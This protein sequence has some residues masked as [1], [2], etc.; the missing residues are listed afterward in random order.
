MTNFHDFS[1]EILSIQ[2]PC[3]TIVVFLSDHFFISSTSR[4]PHPKAHHAILFRHGTLLPFPPRRIPN[5]Q[6]PLLNFQSHPPRQPFLYT[7]T[8]HPPPQP[9]YSASRPSHLHHPPPH[10]PPP[11]QHPRYHNPS[12]QPTTRP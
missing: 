3:F 9:P 12:L 11:L 5:L 8:P 6:L 2:K 4:S 7:L 1:L 10:P